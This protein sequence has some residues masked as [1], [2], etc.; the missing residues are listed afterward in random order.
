MP[1]RGREG[2]PKVNINRKPLPSLGWKDTGCTEPRAQDD[3]IEAEVT[4]HVSGSC[5]SHKG[6]VEG[7]QP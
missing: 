5:G 2:D 4:E 7:T 6:D 3:Q 1:N